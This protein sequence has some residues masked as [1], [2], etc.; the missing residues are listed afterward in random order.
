MKKNK[1]TN[2]QTKTKNIKNIENQDLKDFLV[3]TLAWFNYPW[4][5]L[6]PNNKKLSLF[7]KICICISRE[8]LYT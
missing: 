2:K 4:Q 1:Q 3:E 8:L 7:S 5:N 6:I